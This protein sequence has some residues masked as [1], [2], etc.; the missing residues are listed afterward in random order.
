MLLVFFLSIF[1][2]KVEAEAIFT[3]HGAGLF[4]VETCER[5]AAC[6]LIFLTLM[7]KLSSVELFYCC[8]TSVDEKLHSLK[9]K[10]SDTKIHVYSVIKHSI[11]AG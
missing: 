5:S 11:N 4:H 9:K 6:S 3:L 7:S 1:R 10:K 2:Y 8:L